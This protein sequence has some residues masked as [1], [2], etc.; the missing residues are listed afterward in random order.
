[1]DIS[2]DL[3][4]NEKEKSFLAGRM[5]FD[6]ANEQFAKVRRMLSLKAAGAISEEPSGIP[7]SSQ[8][9]VN[10][11]AVGNKNRIATGIDGDEV[12]RLAED[13]EA[14]AKDGTKPEIKRA[15]LPQPQSETAMTPEFLSAWDEDFIETAKTDSDHRFPACGWYKSKVLKQ[16]SPP[17]VPLLIVTDP[18]GQD[19]YVDSEPEGPVTTPFSRL[20]GQSSNLQPQPETTSRWRRIA[21]FVRQVSERV[22]LVLRRR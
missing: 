7:S 22:A 15:P 12:D 14:E 17:G 1:M 5:G 11:G 19:W 18:E 13:V 8:P 3:K 6:F 4:M 10:D 9:L 21:D 20:P 2:N 16:E